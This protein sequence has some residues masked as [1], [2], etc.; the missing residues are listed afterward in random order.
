MITARPGVWLAAWL[1]LIA[2]AR[3][4]LALTHDTFLGID[5]GAYL[6]GA[7]QYIGG[8]EQ[9]GFLRPPLAPGYILGA[10]VQLW[11]VT[12]FAYNL[13]AALFSL[14]L[15]PA[16]YLLARRVV[17]AKWGA[18]ATVFLTLDWEQ[19]VLFVTG[20]VPVLGFAGICIALWAMVS[21]S[22]ERHEGRA[23]AALI[24][25][26]PL[27]ALSNQ[28]SAGLALISLPLAWLMLPNKRSVAVWLGLGGLMA[29]AV[30]WPWYLHVLPGSAKV[31]YPGALFYLPPVY[32]SVW[33]QATLVMAI[34]GIGWKLGAF[35]TPALRAIAAVTVGHTLVSLVWSN[36]EA[37]MNILFRSNIW[38]LV[39]FWIVLAATVQRV[40]PLLQK[41]L[42]LAVGVSYAVL[43][44]G[45]VLYVYP[46]QFRYSEHLSAEVMD[47]VAS[48]D[49]STVTRWGTNGE[50]RA[51][52]LTAVTGKPA[53][54][55]QSAPP[56]PAYAEQRRLAECE[57]GWQDGCTPT[58]Y[59]SHWI[60]DSTKR[61]GV[62]ALVPNAPNPANPWVDIGE[63][64]PWLE[65]K[66]EIGNV[67]LWL[68]RHYQAGLTAM[69]K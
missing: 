11:G 40:L 46:N 36:D 4:V 18:L 28:T 23:K 54:W 38:A 48:V 3:L 67:S 52:W 2:G 39:P 43:A 64:A 8:P 16:F 57:L 6:L 45:G 21:L 1:A 44:V 5:G 10:F 32:E 17:G 29:V 53:V 66:R 69:G 22:E 47:A 60:I 62:T 50:S 56:Q 19:W 9:S 26:L 25:S 41:R 51:Y 7:F 63:A 24:L 31:A 27:I 14:P 65:N 55:V 68:N 42:V 33:Y 61:Q 49:P 13:Y 59:V 34:T 35:S 37:V 12:P 30:A 20:V 58:G 15:F